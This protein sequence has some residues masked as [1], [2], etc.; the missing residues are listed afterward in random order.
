MGLIE[1]AFLLIQCMWPTNEHTIHGQMSNYQIEQKNVILEKKTNY[2]C[3]E[4]LLL[5]PLGI[6]FG[7][8]LPK[9]FNEIEFS[10]SRQL[11]Q[12]QIY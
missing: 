2:F 11:Q 3:M 10:Y 1:T 4:K 7:P 9:R 6:L 8:V 5:I 12:R